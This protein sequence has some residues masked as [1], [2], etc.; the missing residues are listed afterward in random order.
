MD[1]RDLL[2][3]NTDISQSLLSVDDKIN[4]YSI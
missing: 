1:D 4:L 3:Q 2:N